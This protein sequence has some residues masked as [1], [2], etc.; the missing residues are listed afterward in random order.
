MGTGLLTVV[1]DDQPIV[2]AVRNIME[3]FARESCG[4]CTPCRDGLPWTVKLL[5]AIERGE[6]QPGDIE[7]LE[8]LCGLL[9]PGRTYCALAPGAVEPL[10]SALRFF[11]EEFEQGIAMPALQAVAGGQG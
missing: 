2:P 8:S 10:Q 6:G 9:G 7:V 3:F 5:Q 1:A 11:R 4:W